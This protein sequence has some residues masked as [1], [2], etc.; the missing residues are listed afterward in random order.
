MK[1]DGAGSGGRQR[2]RVTARQPDPF[3][4]LIRPIDVLTRSFQLRHR[5]P[6]EMRFLNGTNYANHCL[7]YE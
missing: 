2:A 5:V 3:G 4:R 7:Y 6:S 1:T